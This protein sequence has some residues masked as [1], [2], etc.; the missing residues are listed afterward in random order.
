MYRTITQA[1]KPL[2]SAPL[3]CTSSSSKEE[4]AELASTEAGY[5][6]MRVAEI[7]K[8]EARAN[9][10]ADRGKLHLEVGAL[11]KEV[12]DGGG[13]V[14]PEKTEWFHNTG[15]GNAE[16]GANVQGNESMIHES[17]LGTP[18]VDASV[19]GSPAT[20][21]NSLPVSV[22]SAILGSVEDRLPSEARPSVEDDGCAGGQERQ[23]SEWRSSPTGEST[24]SSYGEDEFHED[25]DDEDADGLVSGSTP[26]QVEDTNE[27]AGS[28]RGGGG[29]DDGGIDDDGHNECDDDT[30]AIIITSETQFPTMSPAS[31]AAAIAALEETYE[32]TGLGDVIAT[33][34]ANDDDHHHDNNTVAKRQI[35]DRAKG[36]FIARSSTDARGKELGCEEA[37]AGLSATG[38]SGERTRKAM[39]VLLVSEAVDSPGPS[40]EDVQV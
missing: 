30:E 38:P 2:K 29:G 24:G 32:V 1:Q 10:E 36:G 35:E 19:L 17:V 27:A 13:D 23:D 25:N 39:E 5:V 15:S 20:V 22:P 18:E 12:T 40:D 3:P 21:R 11:V 16:V 9:A 34:A 37:F 26:I 14:S 4:T 6:R 31:T 8:R 33:A 28:G 7:E